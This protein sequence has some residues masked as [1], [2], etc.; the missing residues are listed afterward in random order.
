[1]V[2]E[3]KNTDLVYFPVPKVASTTLK[4]F[5]Y[6][7]NHGEPYRDQQDT[8]ADRSKHIHTHDRAFEAI[9]FDNVELASIAQKRRVAVVRDPI[10]RILSAYSNRVLFHGELSPSSIDTKSAELLG[11]PANPS[12]SEFIQYLSE[13]RE[14]SRPIAHHT[15]LQKTFLGSDPGYFE[16]IF[17][18]ERLPNLADLINK[19]AGTNVDIGH[20]QRSKKKIPTWDL[21][22]RQRSE[23]I[24][25]C[26]EDYQLLG[27][28]FSPPPRPIYASVN[29]PPEGAK[30]SLG[31][32]GSPEERPFIIWTLKRSG[33]TNLA[34]FL[35]ENSAFPSLEHEALNEDRERG[36]ITEQW[37]ESGCVDTLKRQLHD[38]FSKSVNIKHCVETV[39][40]PVTQALAEVS[41][42]LGYA[43]LF[44][45]RSNAQDRLLSLQFAEAFNIW[46]AEGLRKNDVAWISNRLRETDLPI[47]ELIRHEI[48]CRE[49]LSSAFNILKHAGVQSA[50]AVFE[51]LFYTPD[52]NVAISVIDR[53]CD[54]LGL[55]PGATGA[56]EQL[57]AGDQGSRERYRDFRN[58]DAFSNAAGKLA[59]FALGGPVGQLPENAVEV[60]QGAVTKLFPVTRSWRSDLLKISGVGVDPADLSASWQV[61][62]DGEPIG[63]FNGL[64]SARFKGENPTLRTAGH[65]RFAAIDVPES[66]LDRIKVKLR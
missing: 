61:D 24:E 4:Q 53:F 54:H 12:L 46:G 44:L 33:G 52:R 5:I 34:K 62:C 60:A 22:S 41:C 48:Q 47:D 32:A 56:I 66:A 13:Y 1:M 26:L 65:A 10:E 28:L 7:V 15:D 49:K 6:E 2:I 16:E 17:P 51:D 21:S 64:A 18:I 36:F 14:L 19:A 25:Y 29:M 20:A 38:E 31:G 57:F 23:L 40:E 42:E 37:R 58:F 9:A 35:F 63:T 55:M 39:P 43:H 59:P 30:A 8:D 50:V 27:E 11:V 45:I 3:V